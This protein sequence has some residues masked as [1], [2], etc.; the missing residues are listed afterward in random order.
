M[1]VADNMDAKTFVIGFGGG[2]AGAL[3]LREI[4]KRQGSSPHAGGYSPSGIVRPTGSFLK[5]GV[6]ERLSY[7]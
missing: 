5:A 7:L 1:V 3:V 4:A 2:L 6:K